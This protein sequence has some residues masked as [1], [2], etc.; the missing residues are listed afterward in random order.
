MTGA[1]AALAFLLALMIACAEAPLQPDLARTNTVAA[2]AKPPSCPAQINVTVSGLSGSLTSDGGD[3]PAYTHNANG[4]LA[5]VTTTRTVTITTSL[6]SAPQ[7]IKS[8]TNTHEQVCGLSGMSANGSA[9][10][11][12]FEVE[13]KDATN[14]Y[15]LRYGK[16]CVGEFGTVVSANKIATTRNANVWT[17]TGGTGTGILCRGRLNGQANWSQVGTADGFTM[18]LTGP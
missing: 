8:Y 17:L 10:T 2:K 16:N 11:A 14:R 12:V 1:A 5:F 6:G 15:I 18:T 7:V 4:N 9:G 13:W 3:Y